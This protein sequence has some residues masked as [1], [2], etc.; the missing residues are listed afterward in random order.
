MNETELLRACMH[1]HDIKEVCKLRLSNT[2]EDTIAWHYERSGLFSVRSAYRL[3]LKID[4][5][6]KRAS[7]SSSRSDGSRPLYNVTFIVAGPS[8]VVSK[9][10]QASSRNSP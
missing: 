5:E 6:E 10:R 1:S 2:M 3:A 8:H 7:G 4:Q 9:G